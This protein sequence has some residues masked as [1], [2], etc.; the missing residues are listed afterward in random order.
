[1][2]TW[3]PMSMSVCLDMCRPEASTE[4]FVLSFLAMYFETGS[5]PN[6]G[7]HQLVRLAIQLRIF[8][9]P[10]QLQDYRHKSPCLA[11]LL[12]LLFWT[13]VLGIQIKTLTHVYQEL[14]PE[15]PYPRGYCVIVEYI[16]VLYNDASR[17]LA[18]SSSITFTHHFLYEKHINLII[19]IVLRCRYQNRYQRLVSS[20]KNLVSLHECSKDTSLC[21][22]NLYSDH[23]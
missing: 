9:S 13:W 18:C 20:G 21:S 1:M 12:P 17:D 22:I 14:Y 15:F 16:Y 19:Y 7:A 5:H 4:Y 2:Y 8:Q 23:S 3:V 10:P 6:L 11:F